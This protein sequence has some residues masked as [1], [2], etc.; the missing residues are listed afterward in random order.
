M[1]TSERWDGSGITTRFYDEFAP[2]RR[3]VF[4]AN[5]GAFWG[6]GVVLGAINR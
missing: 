1:S 3:G 5:L 2:L 6:L 4:G